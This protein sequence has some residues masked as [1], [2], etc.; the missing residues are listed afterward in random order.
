[1]A[2][3]GRG[4]YRD[5]SNV[6]KAAHPERQKIR[7]RNDGRWREE[8]GRTWLKLQAAFLY[9]DNRMVSS[10]NLGWLQTAFDTLMGL[11]DRVGLK[12]N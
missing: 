6:D 3:R 4:D 1:M 11:F 9:A 10:T 5:D 8:R 2:E 7:T 12:T